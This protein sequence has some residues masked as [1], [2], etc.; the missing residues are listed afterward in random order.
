MKNFY[1]TTKINK[2][3][4]TLLVLLGL[5]ES[6]IGLVSTKRTSLINFNTRNMF[7]I[8][9]FKAAL[10]M[11]FLII[12][13]NTGVKAQTT[14]I[15]PAGDGGFESGFGGWTVVNGTTGNQWFT[16]TAAGASAGTKA[17]FIGSSSTTYTDAV[18]QTI[19]VA[20][21]MYKD[22]TF[23]AGQ[24]KVTLTFDYKQPTLDGTFDL[25]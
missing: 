14:L 9:S 25:L 13:A 10:V 7:G 8:Y 5:K 3:V 24:T 16:G 6:T 17:A 18:A 4:S 20:D 11:L 19:T 2:L 1:L 12:G 15:D 21:F 23:P 22:I